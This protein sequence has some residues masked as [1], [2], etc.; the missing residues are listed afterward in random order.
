MSYFEHPA[1]SHSR[2]SLFDTSQGGSPKKFIA[3]KYDEKKD[4]LAMERGSLL[5]TMILEPHLFIVSDVIKPTGQILDFIEGLVMYEDMQVGDPYQLAYEKAGFKRDGLDKV[6]T[7]LDEQINKNYYEYLKKKEGKICLSGADAAFLE[8]CK[9]RLQDHRL[10]NNWFFHTTTFNP[11]Q[12]REQ[13][14]FFTYKGIQSKAKVDYFEVDTIQ[15]IIREVDLK[16]TGRGV[17]N[18]PTG[19]YVH[20][21]YYRQRAFYRLAIASFISQSP[22]YKDIK[23]WSWESYNV[24]VDEYQCEVFRSPTSWIQQGGKEISEIYER[25]KWHY[26]Y[27]KWDYCKEHYENNGIVTINDYEGN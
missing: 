25:L 27:D 4:S 3:Y 20:R 19:D 18:F 15:K 5:H 1:I 26:Q 24:V 9:L 7:R 2:L 16:T 13:E 8:N 23:D 17:Y 21:K 22:L 14:I 6:K 12:F 10:A 11:T